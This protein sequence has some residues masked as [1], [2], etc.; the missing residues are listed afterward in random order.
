MCAQTFVDNFII[1]KT[2]NIESFNSGWF[3]EICQETIIRTIS[4]LFTI[5]VYFSNIRRRIIVNEEFYYANS[6]K[7]AT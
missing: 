1:F 3:G 5:T 6:N 7:D 2:I 4:I